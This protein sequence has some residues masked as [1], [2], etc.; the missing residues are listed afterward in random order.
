M[1]GAASTSKEPYRRSTPKLVELK[2]EIKE[3]L[4]EYG[5]EGGGLSPFPLPPP[6]EPSPLGGLELSSCGLVFLSS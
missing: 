4:E 5:G 3:M 1:P 6:K 2:L